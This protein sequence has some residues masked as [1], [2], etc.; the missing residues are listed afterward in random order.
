MV[1]AAGLSDARHRAVGKSPASPATDSP[2]PRPATA[3][4]PRV[5]GPRPGYLPRLWLPRLLPSGDLTSRALKPE[6]PWRPEEL[7]L[8]EAP[9]S[10][11][12]GQPASQRFRWSQGGAHLQSHHSRQPQSRDTAAPASCD[13]GLS[14]QLSALGGAGLW[15]P[16]TSPVSGFFRYGISGPQFFTLGEM[17]TDSSSELRATGSHQLPSLCGHGFLKG[18]LP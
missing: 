8:L 2:R 16:N 13:R 1:W 4:E 18:E 10:V 9:G 11:W 3:A 7:G 15:C 14:H 6:A 17:D 5:R 12:K